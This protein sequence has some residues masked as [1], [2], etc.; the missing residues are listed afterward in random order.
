M[1]S[2]RERGGSPGPAARPDRDGGVPSV[3]GCGRSL[4]R[5]SRCDLGWQRRHKR[6]PPW[7]GAGRAAGGFLCSRRTMRPDGRPAERA[8]S[9]WLRSPSSLFAGARPCAPS[10]GR[11]TAPRGH[12]VPPAHPLPGP[13]ARGSG[14]VLQPPEMPRGQ[15]SSGGGRGSCNRQR[16]LQN[17]R[18][19]LPPAA[20]CGAGAAGGDAA[21]GPVV[22]PLRC[23]RAAPRSRASGSAFSR[24]RSISLPGEAAPSPG[25]AGSLALH[26]EPRVTGVSGWHRARRGP[27]ARLRSRRDTRG[28]CCCASRKPR[29]GMSLCVR[30]RDPRAAQAGLR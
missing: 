29:A 14:G 17:I 16:E 25:R 3:A 6:P 12:L 21:P 26:A 10:R 11:G 18:R 28:S 4:R 15:I 24:S 8:R 5:R 19:E 30:P 27:T 9:A 7:E 20:P 1:G 22:Q 13:Q 2:L 23:G